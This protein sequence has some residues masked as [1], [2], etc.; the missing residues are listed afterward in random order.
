MLDSQQ[1]GH[2]GRGY[3]VGLVVANEVVLGWCY[4]GRAESEG[5]G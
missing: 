5:I 2:W 1:V 3:V 4:G